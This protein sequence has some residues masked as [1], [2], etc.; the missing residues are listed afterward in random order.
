MPLVA[1]GFGYS[2]AWRL[3]SWD[4]FALPKPYARA[5]GVVSPPMV[6]PANLDREGVEHYR[7]QVEQM[8]NRMTQEAES[9]AVAGTPK[10]GEIVERRQGAWL[11]LHRE[12]AREPVVSLW[13]ESPLEGMP[14]FRQAS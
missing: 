8:L 1:M 13:P 4:R 7:L 6:I 5:R 2:D 14:Q 10:I 12:R 3:G 11:N 9:W